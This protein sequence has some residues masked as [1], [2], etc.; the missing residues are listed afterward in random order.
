MENITQNKSYAFALETIKIYKKLVG[1]KKEYVLSKQLLRS[2]TSIGAMLR[3]SKF[4]QS[5]LDFISKL[6]IGLKEANESLYWIDLLHDS[7]FINDEDYNL[8]HSNCNELISLLVA[9]IKTLKDSLNK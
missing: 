9:S 2:G 6:S 5:S 1:E 7:D 4:A 3:E 8:L